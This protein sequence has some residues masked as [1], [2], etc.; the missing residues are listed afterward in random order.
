MQQNYRFQQMNGMMMVVKSRTI[1]KDFLL[2]QSSSKINMECSS[3]TA[4]KYSKMKMAV[5]M[6][7]GTQN[8][9]I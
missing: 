6:K 2:R 7:S 9:I 3:V 8:N 5:K 4:T 1:Q